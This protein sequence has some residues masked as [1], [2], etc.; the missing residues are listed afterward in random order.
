MCAGVPMTRTRQPVIGPVANAARRPGTTTR[1]RIE[2]LHDERARFIP[3][4]DDVFGLQIAVDDAVRVC[5]RGSVAVE[6]GP[7]HYGGGFP[8]GIRP[9]GDRARRAAMPGTTGP[10]SITG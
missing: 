3:A 10:I 8:G 4:S 9:E 1:P 6:S 5:A 7:N 2:N